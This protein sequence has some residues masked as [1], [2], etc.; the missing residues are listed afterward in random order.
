MWNYR[1]IEFVDPKEGQWRA[2]HEVYY[3]DNGKPEGYTAIPAQLLA[4]HDS[5]E[6]RDL[7]WILDRMREALD[8][9]VLTERDFEPW[10]ETNS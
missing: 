5:G 1:V 10:T 8:R 2:I 9:P 3:D 7:R 4:F 6:S